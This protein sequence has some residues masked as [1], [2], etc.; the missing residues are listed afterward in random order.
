MLVPAAQS[1]PPRRDVDAGHLAEKHLDVL[2]ARQ[3]AADRLGDIGRRQRRGRHLIEQR[4]EQVVVVAVD[5][6]DVDL[7]LAEPAR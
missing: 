6:R 7:G 5:D 1:H 2:L 3:H 4:H